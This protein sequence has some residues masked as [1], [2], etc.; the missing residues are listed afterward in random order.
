MQEQFFLRRQ[1]KNGVHSIK[2][3]IIR[4]NSKIE[5]KK[6]IYRVSQKY[7][8]LKLLVGR[9]FFGQAILRKLTGL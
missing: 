7:F 1:E 4:P 6:Y 3:A 5:H 9:C 8:I 2:R